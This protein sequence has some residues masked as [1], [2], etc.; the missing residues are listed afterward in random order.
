MKVYITKYAMTEG[1]LERE[2]KIVDYLDG[3][4]SVMVTLFPSHTYDT[5]LARWEY[6][7]TREAAV[8]IANKMKEKKIA[9][10]EKQLQKIKALQF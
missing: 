5:L 10:L 8:G 1:I 9:S 2:A 6:F 3:D 4:Q 7:E